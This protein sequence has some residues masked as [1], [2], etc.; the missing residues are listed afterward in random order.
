MF[1]RCKYMNSLPSINAWN[2]L[3][4]WQPSKWLLGGKQYSLLLLI[5]SCHVS[6][7]YFTDCDLKLYIVMMILRV[8]AMWSQSKRILGVLLLLYVPRVSVAFVFTG[9][10]YGPKTYTSSMY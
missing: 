8:Y 7:F 1:H 10:F 5:V 6:S 3:K 2:I 9:I 4:V